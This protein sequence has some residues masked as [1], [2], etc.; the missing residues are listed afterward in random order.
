MSFS[1]AKRKMIS[2]IPIVLT[3]RKITNHHGLLLRAEC[4]KAKPFHTSDH[5]T[6]TAINGK[7]AAKNGI[8]SSHSWPPTPPKPPWFMYGFIPTS[9]Y[10]LRLGCGE[11]PY[12]LPRSVFRLGV[13]HPEV[14]R[15]T[16]VGNLERPVGAFDGSHCTFNI[17]GDVNG[18]W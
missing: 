1:T 5:K 16:F 2:R 17:C 12:L 10:P 13:A 14:E 15:H 18:A 4:H 3:T 9:I 7:S 6:I 11:A 8:V